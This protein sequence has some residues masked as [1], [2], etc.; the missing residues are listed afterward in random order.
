MLELRDFIS[1][2]I[3]DIVEGIN[4]A[5][6]R[7][8]G[9]DALVSPALV[10]ERQMVNQN[11]SLPHVERINFDVALT[12]S[13]SS[14]EGMD[15]SG[16]VG[17]KVLSAKMEGKGEQAESSSTVSRIQFSLPIILPQ[18]QYTRAL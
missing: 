7:L 18:N 5:N 16:G 12:A 2:V 4:D 1:R 8:E 14:K 13:E 11:G 9:K 3:V 17:V 15:V 10:H 6:G